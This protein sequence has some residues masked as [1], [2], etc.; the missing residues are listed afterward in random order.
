MSSDISFVE[1]VIN[2]IDSGKQISFKKMFGEYAIYLNGKV[3]ALICDNQLFVKP[4]KSGKEF[5][6]NEKICEEAPYPGAKL[7]FLID[8]KIDDKFWL[9]SLFE[10]TENELPT[11]KPKL[12]K[13]KVKK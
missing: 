9:T 10:I 11:P 13:L 7:W 4:T 1:F 8:D 12:K 5:M 2:Q 3:V 6:E